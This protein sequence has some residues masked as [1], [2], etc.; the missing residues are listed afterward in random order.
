MKA[1]VMV[2]LA[3]INT[4]DIL[5]LVLKITLVSDMCGMETHSTA[6]RTL[7]SSDFIIDRECIEDWTVE[8]AVVDVGSLLTTCT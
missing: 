6:L 3:T 2:G 8:Q 4:T 7:V 5:V 1:G